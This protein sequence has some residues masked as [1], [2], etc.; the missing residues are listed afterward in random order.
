MFEDEQEYQQYQNDQED[1]AYLSWLEEQR[2]K[3]EQEN[4][5]TQ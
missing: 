3:D 2:M 1:E 5:S 4:T